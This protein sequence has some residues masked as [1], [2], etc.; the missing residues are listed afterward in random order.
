MSGSAYSGAVPS[1]ARAV[2]LWLWFIALLVV[3]MITVGGATRLTDSGLSITEWKPILGAIPPLSHADWMDAFEKY[4]QIPEYRLVNKGM[5]LEAFQF[6]YWWEWG[7]RFL[8]RFIGVAFGLP[9]L[10]F[11]L[12][13][14]LAPSYAL[15]LLGVM[16]LGGVQGGIGWFMVMSG[17]VDR[18]DVSH[19]RLALHL[20]VAFVILALVVWLALGVRGKSTSTDARCR[21]L[22]QSVAAALICLLFIQ[23]VLG[24]FVAGLKGGLV[25]NTWPLMTGS[26]IA[27]DAWALEPWYVNFVENP[28]MAQLLHRLT[29]YGLIGVGLWQA[30]LVTARY[31]DRRVATSGI[32]VFGLICIQGALGI[33]TLLAMVPISLG[34]AHQGFAAI[35]LIFA[36]RHL[37]LVTNAPVG[38]CK[39]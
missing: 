28:A 17:L 16:A 24:A 13:G 36:V 22:L 29:A 4:R 9:L 12:R 11:W 6:I 25:H 21:C 33:W 15:K 8:G 10:F 27:E 38:T 18:V 7:H 39:V 31:S 37:F 5:S 20:T 35:V 14:A 30:W 19:Y 2:E 1:W 3:L 34:V 32:I 23:V 26:F